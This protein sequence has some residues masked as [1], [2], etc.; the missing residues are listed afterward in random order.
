ML[1]GS[2][3]YEKG[4]SLKPA[5]ML[6]CWLLSAGSLGGWA[7]SLGALWAGLWA[8][9]C[10]VSCDGSLWALGGWDGCLKGLG[11]QLGVPQL[12]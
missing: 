10:A 4:H 7:G 2:N 8:V 5:A 1:K 6:C 12:P 11:C 9:L 3:S